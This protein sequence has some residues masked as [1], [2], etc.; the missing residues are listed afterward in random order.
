MTDSHDTPPDPQPH[1]PW[2][3]A[4]T[5][6][7]PPAAGGAPAAPPRVRGAR[8]RAVSLLGASA[9]LLG[10]GTVG[11]F[12]GAGLADASS[13]STTAAS[14]T[15][16]RDSSSGAGTAA[17]AS[18][19]TG[20]VQSAARTVS[21]SVVTIAVQGQPDPATGSSGA[22]TGSGVVIRS[23]GYILTNNHVVESA[24]KG[25]SVSV[26]FA[27]GRTAKANIV[28]RDPASDLAVIKV[29]GVTGLN[30]ATFAD[31]DQLGIGQTV[32]ALGSPLGL[33]GTVTE[34]IV[35]ALHRPVRT[36]A[37]TAADPQSTVLDAVQTDAAINPGNSGGALVDL[38]GRVVGINSAIATL[39]AGSLPGQ[40][41][42]S[43][44][45]GVGFA[46]PANT[47]VDVA[48]Q[49]IAT[50]TARH[51]YIGVSVTDARSGILSRGATL[52][53][54][55]PGGPAADAGLRQGDVVTGVGDRRITDADALVAAIRSHR[56]GD[57]VQLS[58][59]RG[60]HSQKATVTLAGRAG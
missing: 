6:P 46:I 38:A 20:T 16:V 21:P 23:N 32:I 52:Q 24:A 17:P 39:G 5:P 30:A 43:G 10:G 60:G 50:G 37:S 33:D 59:L 41:T 27:D 8:S 42:Q 11:G 3:P 53:S 22:G 9:L 58:Y 13:S 56:A 36:G 48:D 2:A 31:S 44:N 45:I 15:V 54:V 25:G 18:L 28:G 19:P 12:V 51:A 4:T 26:S 7:A 29:S 55:V 35:S 34:G 14:T 47:A 57:Q 49:L 1:D 40:S